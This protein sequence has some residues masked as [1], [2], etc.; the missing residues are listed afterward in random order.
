V[1][2]EGRDINEAGCITHDHFHLV[3][4]LSPRGLDTFLGSTG[5][6]HRYAV[7]TQ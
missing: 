2:A 7:V 6:E 3:A 4:E 1:L 5:H